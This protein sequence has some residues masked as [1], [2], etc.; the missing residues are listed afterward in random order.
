MISMNRKRSNPKGLFV[1][2]AIVV[3]LTVLVGMWMLS[4][5]V[6][7]NDTVQSQASVTV[8][9]SCQLNSTINSAHESDVTPG[10]YEHDIGKT[11]ISAT[12]NDANGYAVYAIGYTNT[13]YGRN[14]MLGQTTGRT[15]DT[16]TATSGASSN[17]AMKLT[18]VASAVAPTIETAFQ[19]YNDV[20]DEYTKVASYGN[21]TAN[22]VAGSQFE[23]TYAAYVSS[24][25][26]PDVY[27]GKVKYTLVHPAD[28]TN[29]PCTETYTIVY[30][31]NGGTGSMDSQT[32]CMDVPIALLPS[33][34]TPK[35][36]VL[37]NQ[38][39]VWNTE[40]DGSGYTYY[41]RQSVANLASPGGAITLYA[42]WVPRY[43]QDLTPQICEIAAKEA[44]ITVLDRRDG[45]DYTVRFLQ[46]ACWMT[47][48]LRI[49]GTVNENGSNFSTYSNVNVCEGDLTSGNSNDEPR[50]H[51]SGNTTNGVWYNYAATSAK[52][53]LTGNTEATEDI[54]PAGWHLPNRDYT[55]KPAGS[56]DSMAGVDSVT[57]TAFNPV[58]G[59]YYSSGSLS[60][61]GSGYWWSSM[62][63]SSDRYLLYFNGSR[64][65][66]SRYDRSY[67]FYIRCVRG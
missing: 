16:G 63:V 45:N 36:P 53:I 25:Q 48:N 28:T 15:I 49:T 39:G 13:E 14:D 3:G 7:A 55:N 10:T 38:F 19:S 58:A 31:A 43:I 57:R 67:G 22:Y 27:V 42:Q 35:A 62:G 65:D 30:N 1:G 46:G 60:S 66:T 56:I 47:Q 32:G 6:Q 18:S 41:P 59:G 40:Q 24:E 4:S 54:C 52:T 12:C 23:T 64:L 17:W 34:F 37:E 11:T 5:R 20:P 21:S 51:D 44:P 33:G 26:A 29:A 9:S 2:D 8:A 61:T 50:C